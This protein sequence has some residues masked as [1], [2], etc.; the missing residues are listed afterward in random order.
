MIDAA[1]LQAIDRDFPKIA[2]PGLFPLSALTYGEAF[3]RLIG[4]VRSPT[5]RSLLERRFDIDLEDAAL[6]ITVRGHCQARDG[7]IHNDSRDKLVTALIYLNSAGWDA[8]GG[9]LR[10]LRDRNDLDSTVAEVAPLGGNFVA[11]RR[12]DNSWHGHA[13]FEGPRRYIMFNWLRS[14]AALGVNLSRHRISSAFK[15]AGRA[16][17]S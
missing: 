15:S 17:A 5:M 13:S 10:L 16:R 3:D 14:K 9:R 6:L 12:T 4:G 8:D 2:R 11:F 7:R 1:D